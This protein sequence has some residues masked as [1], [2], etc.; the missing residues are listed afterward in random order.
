MS[1]VTALP[2]VG[3]KRAARIVRARPV[4]GLDELRTVFD[5]PGLA[6]RL[7]GMLDYG[8]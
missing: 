8:F 2:G 5:E 3:K 4:S 7:D 1:A 6:E